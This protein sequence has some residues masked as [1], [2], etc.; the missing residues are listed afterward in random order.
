MLPVTRSQLEKFSKDAILRFAKELG[1]A[2]SSRHTKE[3]VI[4]M[5]W[6]SGKGYFHACLSQ[7]T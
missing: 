6:I 1:L 3:E 4:Y 7:N 2:V 5:I